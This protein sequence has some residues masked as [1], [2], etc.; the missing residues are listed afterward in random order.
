MGFV[1]YFMLGF[2]IGVGLIAG[3]LFVNKWRSGKRMRKAVEISQLGRLVLSEIKG[4]CG[5]EETPNWINFPEY[6][7]VRWMNLMLKKI[8]PNVSKAA[9]ALI[10][11]SVE[12]ILEQYRPIGITSM[13]FNKLTLG[14]IAPQLGGVKVYSIPERKGEAIM[15]LDFKWTGDPSIILKVATPVVSLPIQVKDLGFT[16]KVRLIFKF[17]D[18]IPAIG[19]VAVSLR[20]QPKPDINYTLKAV[21]GSISAVPGL[22]GMIY[23]TIMDTVTDMLVW[24]H[25]IIVPLDDGDYSDMEL[26]LTGL[27]TVKVV[28]GKGLKNVD[29]MGKSDPYVIVHTRVLWPEKTKIIDNNLNPEWNEQ[30][31][32]TCDDKETQRLILEVM[33]DGKIKDERLGIVAIPLNQLQDN[34]L[35][36]FTVELLPDIKTDDVKKENLGTITV[37][38]MY[39]PFTPEE[40]VAAMEKE[41]RIKLEREKK[42]GLLN[43][44][45]RMVTGVAGAAGKMVGSGVGAVGS[46]VLAVGGG[47]GTGV[48][49][50][51]GGVA[52]GVG[53]VAGGV[54]S[55]GKFMAN[56]IT[57]SMGLSRRS[58][59]KSEDANDLK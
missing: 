58:A 29:V 4:I 52:G 49:A 40:Q 14:N 36:Q 46:G 45:M 21:G 56:K 19:A 10:K 22:D 23:S 32:L 39:H 35:T 34:K 47:V 48:T 12:P 43:D 13:K 33:D 5:P 38:L 57:G 26:K 44:S 18:K 50:V 28:R 3:Q 8:W 24:P 2:L 6:E 7:R 11:D 55:A 31:E 37:D 16:A 25:R 27:L 53:A 20:D 54:G 59:S 41:A 17:I 42:A 1:S 15:E 51:A 9:S 30:F